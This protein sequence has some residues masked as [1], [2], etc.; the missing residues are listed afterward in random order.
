MSLPLPI[1]QR[2]EAHPPRVCR[3]L[4]TKRA[5]NAYVTDG[6]ATPW[7]AGESTTAVFWCLKTMDTAG[8]DDC[9]AHPSTCCDGRVCF[10]AE[11]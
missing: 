7:E 10:R 9:F 5:F 6:D 3:L 8:P 11:F 1:D 4:R 2:A